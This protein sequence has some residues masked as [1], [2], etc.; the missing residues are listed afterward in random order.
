MNMKNDDGLNEFL[1]ATR[2]LDEPAVI[3]ITPSQLLNLGLAIQVALAAAESVEQ[4]ELIPYLVE[5]L[6]TADDD[7]FGTAANLIADELE[8]WRKMSSLIESEFAGHPG[9]IAMSQALKR[10]REAT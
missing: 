1:E 2:R 9:T 8:G 6:G 3:E 7:E 10:R 5:R 4:G